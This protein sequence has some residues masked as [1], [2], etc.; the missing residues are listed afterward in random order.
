MSVSQKNECQLIDG[1][2]VLREFI[3]CDQAVIQLCR[4]KSRFKI[5]IGTKSKEEG[6]RVEREKYLT[7]DEEKILRNLFNL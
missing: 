6:F 1:Q 7:E 3:I 4:V 5:V 2:Q